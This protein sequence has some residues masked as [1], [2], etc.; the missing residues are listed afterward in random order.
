MTTYRSKS[1][2]IL[3]LGILITVNPFSIDMY[4]PAFDSIAKDLHTTNSI[5]SLTLSSYFIGIAMG[6]LFYGPLLDRF[7]RKKPLCIG[8]CIYIIA[9]LGCLLS[10][11]VDQLIVLRFLQ[12]IGG[13]AAQVTAMTMVR[14]FFPIEENAK[15]FSLLVLV[16]SVS[17]L[18]APSIGS[19]LALWL[20][21]QSV[22]GL[23]IIIAVLICMMVILFLP[24]GYQPDASISL[25]LKPIFYNFLQILCNQQFLTFALAG[26]LSMTGLFVYIASSPIIFME[27]FKVNSTIYGF[28]FALL[29]LGFIG[30]S[31]IN[32]LISK[33][34]SIHHVF[35]VGITAQVLIALFFLLGIANQ[36]YNIYVTF[37]FIFFQLACLGLTYPNAAA[38][39]IAPFTRNIGSASALLGFLQIGTAALVSSGISLISSTNKILPPAILMAAMPLIGLC[40][41]LFGLRYF[42]PS[43]SPTSQPDR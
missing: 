13:C 15:I 23:L 7:G 10:Q 40:I 11:N 20:G 27:V 22:F 2:I 34:F 41:L 29:S 24:K 18:L 16:L 17:P 39:A 26:A 19:F 31:Q 4:L 8:L 25:R 43:M 1:L 28:I 3:I 37:C 12:A 9:S 38:M 30:S 21:W 6:Q 42:T 33:R 36:W 32:A 14:D 35:K 5:L